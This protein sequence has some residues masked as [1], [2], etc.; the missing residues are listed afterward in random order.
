MNK[1]STI[2]FAYVVGLIVQSFGLS[3]MIRS[4]LGRFL[5]RMEPDGKS[6]S[7]ALECSQRSAKRSDWHLYLRVIS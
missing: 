1:T 6:R 7:N 3:L 2:L 5:G 4:D